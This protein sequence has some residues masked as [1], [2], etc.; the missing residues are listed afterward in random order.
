LREE[1]YIDVKPGYVDT[2]ASPNQTQPVITNASASANQ[3][4]A[5]RKKRKKFL[6][7]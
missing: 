3:H 5:K 4:K 7:L 1:S 2:G 6:F